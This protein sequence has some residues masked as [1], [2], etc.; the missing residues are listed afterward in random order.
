MRIVKEIASWAAYIIGAFVIAALLNIFVFQITTVEGPSMLPTLHSGDMYVISKLG[1]TLKSTPDYEDIV[2]IDS[3]VSQKRTFATDV[4]D[5]F[6]YNMLTTLF[7]KNKDQT[8]W[9]KRVIGRPGDVIR[10]AS[11]GKV[12][13]NGEAL[14]EPY[15]NDAEPIFYEERTIT[16]PE[17]YIWVMGDNRNHSSDSR[18]LG[19]VPLENVIGELKFKIRSGSAIK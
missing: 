18:I 3:R 12:Y 17:G 16:V 4:S 1:H 6:H 8:Y 13:R 2:V 15:V 5:I 11:D 19:P 10:M 14:A 7:G 9:V